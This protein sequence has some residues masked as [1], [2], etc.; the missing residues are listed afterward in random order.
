MRG[1]SHSRTLEKIAPVA[2]YEINDL[3]VQPSRDFKNVTVCELL[4]RG[5]QDDRVLVRSDEVVPGE[6]RGGERLNRRAAET[7]I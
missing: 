7:R 4:P 3:I 6:L 5:L 2:I 1:W